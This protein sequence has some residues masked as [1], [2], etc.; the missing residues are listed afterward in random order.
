MKLLSPRAEVML[1]PEHSE[2]LYEPCLRGGFKPHEVGNRVECKGCA[3]SVISTTPFLRKHA[4]EKQ[5]LSDGSAGT[6]AEFW[7]R[8]HPPTKEGDGR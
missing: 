7:D 6:C 4:Y 5:T 2:S 8:T 3:K 1:N